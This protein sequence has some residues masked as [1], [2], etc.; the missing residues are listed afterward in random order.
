MAAI[1]NVDVE[2]FFPR[3]CWRWF[4]ILSCLGIKHQ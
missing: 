4:G 3:T 1:R 2:G